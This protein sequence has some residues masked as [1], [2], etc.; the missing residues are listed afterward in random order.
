MGLDRVMAGFG[1]GVRC[2]NVIFSL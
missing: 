2:L 1:V